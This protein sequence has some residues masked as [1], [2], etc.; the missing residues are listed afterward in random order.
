M[1]NNATNVNLSSI[2][3]DTLNVTDM[4]SMYSTSANDNTVVKC[5]HN[6]VKL[7]EEDGKTYC[8]Y[9]TYFAA[10]AALKAKNLKDN[11]DAKIA[12]E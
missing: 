1:F 10:K 7:L 6:Y 5:T 4:S 9:H 2:S 3:W 8:Q 12:K 11:E